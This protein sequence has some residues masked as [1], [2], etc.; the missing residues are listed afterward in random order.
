MSEQLIVY[1]LGEKGVN[2][3]KDPLDLDP[4]ELRKAQN[5][6]SYAGLVNRPGLEKFNAV[7]TAGSVVGGIGVPILNLK[8]GTRFFFIGRGPI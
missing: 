3:D 2:V 5:A 6:I 4:D 7:T 8:T 1:T